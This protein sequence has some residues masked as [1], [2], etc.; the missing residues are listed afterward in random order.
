MASAGFLSKYAGTL[1][2]DVNWKNV[3][4]RDG[5]GDAATNG[6]GGPG[7]YSL[8]GGSLISDRLEVGPAR[9]FLATQLKLLLPNNCLY[10]YI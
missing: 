8:A 3:E 5:W 6:R 4:P 10:C 1:R 9:F 2:K 7:V